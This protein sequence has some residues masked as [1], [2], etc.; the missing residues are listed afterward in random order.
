MQET[1]LAS[2]RNEAGRNTT[3]V[4]VLI[5]YINFVNKVI[6]IATQLG[7]MS[8]LSGLEH[9]IQVLVVKVIRV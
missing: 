3:L 4:L 1:E 6:V 8:W 5:T 2:R 7:E 9:Q